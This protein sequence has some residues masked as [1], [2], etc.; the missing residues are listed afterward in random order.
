MNATGAS[1]AVSPVP[2][3]KTFIG[4]VKRHPIPLIFL[5]S[6]ALFAIFIPDRFLTG[7]NFTA[8]LRQFVT[9]MLFAIGPSIVVLLGS[10]DLSFVG[11]WMLGSALLWLTA[12]SLGVAALLVFPVFGII[13]GFLAGLLHT[14]GKVPSFVLTLS[15]L[16]VYWGITVVVAGGYP[17]PVSGFEFLTATIIPRVPT[18]FL[19]SL[20]IIALAWFLME[21]TELGVYFRAIGSNEE[22]ARLAGIKVEKM[23]ILAFTLSGAFTGLGCMLL[24]QHLGGSV[25]VEFNL[26][27]VVHPL[28]TIILGGTPLVGGSGGPQRTI[29]G[30]LSFSV[31]YRGLY[32]SR[33]RPEMID[34]V[35]GVLLIIAIVISSRGTRMKGVSIT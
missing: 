2:A 21:R 4:L 31:F 16:I 27:A 23:K 29:F 32:L 17:R 25:P 13:S 7:A 30:V 19:L 22:G 5:V 14:K 6:V 1:P 10:L 26:N 8:V 3:Q 12:P 34:L 28:V 20:P 24:F 15:M 35:V 18:P 11:I 33:L 9:L